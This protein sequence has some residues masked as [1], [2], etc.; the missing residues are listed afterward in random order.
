MVIIRRDICSSITAKGGGSN[1]VREA[2]YPIPSLFQKL[3]A[4]LICI[5]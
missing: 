5:G 2:V 4:V 1:E 3:S